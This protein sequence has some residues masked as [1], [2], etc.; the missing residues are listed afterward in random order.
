MTS[1]KVQVRLQLHNVIHMYCMCM[2]TNLQYEFLQYIC[3]CIHIYRHTY[4]YTYT[5]VRMYIHI[6]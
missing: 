1:K 5:C 3:A 2:G 6:Q 4:V